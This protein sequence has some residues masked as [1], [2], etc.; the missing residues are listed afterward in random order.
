MQGGSVPPALVAGPLGVGAASV[1]EASLLRAGQHLASELTFSV[2]VLEGRCSEP[3]G[4]PTRTSSY[5]R[6]TGPHFHNYI[7]AQAQAKPSDATLKEKQRSH[8][9]LWESDKTDATPEAIAT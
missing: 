8:R 4:P 9:Q 3:P 2:D 7:M 6:Y 1:A 5:V